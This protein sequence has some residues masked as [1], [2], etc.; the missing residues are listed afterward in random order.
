[1]FIQS[2]IREL[3]AI[4]T[5]KIRQGG[6]TIPRPTS[7]IPPPTG[8]TKLNVDAAVGRGSRHGSVA[9]ISRDSTGL[10][11]GASAVVFAGI[12]DPATLECMAI[13]EA[14]ALAD[15]LNVSTIQ[16]ASDSKVVVED[17]RENNPTT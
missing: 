12:S 17:I 1:M 16:V 15:N 2:Y 11:L 10:F 4:K 8:M 14:L 7:W 9:A 6:N 13:R 5:V 3:E